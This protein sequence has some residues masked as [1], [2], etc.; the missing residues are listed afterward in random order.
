[1]TLEEGGTSLTSAEE[2]LKKAAKLNP[3]G[4]RKNPTKHEAY[5]NHKQSQMNTSAVEKQTLPPP[6]PPPPPDNNVT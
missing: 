6:P 5:D 1:M 3:V 4:E 2:A